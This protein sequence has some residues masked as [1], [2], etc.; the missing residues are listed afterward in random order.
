MNKSLLVGEEAA[1]LSGIDTAGER[2]VSKGDCIETEELDDASID[3]AL[4]TP[5]STLETIPRQITEIMLLPHWDSR[6]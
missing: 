4:P 5:D 3:A 6:H 2:V 1:E